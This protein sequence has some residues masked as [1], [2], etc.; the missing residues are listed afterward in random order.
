MRNIQSIKANGCFYYNIPTT[1]Q[2]H[3]YETE[4]IRNFQD[5]LHMLAHL[6]SKSWMDEDKLKSLCIILANDLKAWK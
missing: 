3:F 5:A 4:A 6:S 2:F 1:S